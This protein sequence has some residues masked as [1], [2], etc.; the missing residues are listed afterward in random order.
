MQEIGLA[1][2]QSGFAHSLDE[3]WPS[4][5]IGFPS[6]SGQL[7]P[8][9]GGHGIAHPEH[10]SGWRRGPRRLAISEVLIERSIAAEGVRAGGDAD[11]ATTAWSCAPSRTSTRWVCTPATPSP[12]RRPDADDVEY[13]AMRDAA[14]ACIAG[15]VETGGSNVQ[16]AST[17][18][19]HPVVIE[20][21]RGCR[22]PRR[23]LEGDRLPIARSPPP[24]RRLPPGRDHQRHHGA[25]PASFEP[26]STTWSP[27]SR[28]AF[29]K[30]PGDRPAGT[31]MQS[32][33]R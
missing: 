33:G 31:R 32:S 6:W 11:N 15:R 9:R 8:R 4:G 1:V 21:N 18:R 13:Q 30:L 22:G 5:V 10:S 12:W 2:P 27:R 3:A 24:R 25:T 17:H 19:R 23:W 16:F 29:E 20:M 14:F 7:H 26:T 28:W